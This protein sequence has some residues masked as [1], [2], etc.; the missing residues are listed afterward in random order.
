QCLFPP[1]VDVG[2]TNTVAVSGNTVFLNVHA[3]GTAP[4]TYQWFFDETNSL[5]YATNATLVLSNVTPAAAGSYAVVVANPYGSVTSAPAVVTILVPPSILC[6]SNR[7]VLLGS[8][9]GFDPPA[10]NG[11][12]PILSVVSTITNNG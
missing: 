11:S 1:Q 12:A 8:S 10:V 5:T 7:T 9:W 4:L 6:V 2:P 3:Q